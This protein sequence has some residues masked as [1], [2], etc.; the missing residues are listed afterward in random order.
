M[1]IL[2]SPFDQFE[3]HHFGS[4]DM[5]KNSVDTELSSYMS[6]GFFILNDKD[7]WL[8]LAVF[9][10]SW[11]PLIRSRYCHSVSQGPSHAQ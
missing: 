5:W 1:K 3:K 11:H 10:S 4:E 9:V 8:L 7:L 2:V 6:V